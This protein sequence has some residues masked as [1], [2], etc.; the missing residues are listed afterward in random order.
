MILNGAIINKELRE[1]LRNPKIFRGSLLIL[2]L[3]GLAFASFWAT[4]SSH[5]SMSERLMFARVSFAGLSGVGLLIFMLIPPLL[6]ASA[7][8]AERE[9][10]TY[11][12]LICTPLSR[13]QILLGKWLS[14]I[15]YQLILLICLMPIVALIF[16]LGGVGLDEIAT[17][18]MILLTTMATYSM[19]GL[20]MSSR[21]RRSASSLVMTILIIL[22]LNVGMLL[23]EIFLFRIGQQWRGGA[24]PADWI[25]CTTSP[26]VNWAAYMAGVF[27]PKISGA[28]LGFFSLVLL[29]HLAF[30]AVLFTLSLTAALRNMLQRETLRPVIAKKVIRDEALLERR[31]KKWPY[32]LIDPQANMQHIADTANPVLAKEIR[33][34]ILSRTHIL[35]RLCYIGFF[36]SIGLVFLFMSVDDFDV[37]RRIAHIV[38]SIV[39]IFMPLLSAT[40]V[41]KEKEEGTLP[42]LMNTLLRPR[43]IIL[44]KFSAVLRFIGIISASFMVVPCQIFLMITISYNTSTDEFIGFIKL[45]PTVF[46]Y[47]AF[48]CAFG[49]Y[50]SCHCKKGATAVASTYGMLIFV[51]FILMGLVA[52]FSPHNLIARIG[53]WPNADDVK[54]VI[55]GLAN[56][57]FA[58]VNPYFYLNSNDHIFQPLDSWLRILAHTACLLL[59]TAGLLWRS[60]R[61]LEKQYDKN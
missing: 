15:S 56:Q 48:F 49:L 61:L 50:F 57:F 25:V 44:A 52:I 36:S 26:M 31:R 42:L 23:F 34:G 17:A 58:I 47:S 40:L 7:I 32:Y 9:G 20:A 29:K 24:N 37:S 21:Y 12:M 13:L 39:L 16:Q 3:C 46:G 28:R 19:L 5:I 35:I 30:Q 43:Q 38:L 53:L 6:T 45:V 1:V 41:T 27:S 22:V 54:A 14:V 4:A 18:L 59:F 8:T 10:K 11:E 33:T 60:V 2:L 55:D 51:L